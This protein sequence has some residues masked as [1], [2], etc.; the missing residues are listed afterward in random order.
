MNIW[1]RS[2]LIE[3]ATT[4]QTLNGMTKK[5]NRRRKLRPENNFGYQCVE[6]TTIQK[7]VPKSIKIW[8]NWK[9]VM[10]SVALV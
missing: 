2:L 6:Q 8:K 9:E 3:V 4:L 5:T 7:V 1:K 10:S